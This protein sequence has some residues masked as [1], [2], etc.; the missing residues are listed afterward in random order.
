MTRIDYTSAPIYIY[1]YKNSYS[2]QSAKFFPAVSHSFSTSAPCER[3][4]NR[5]ENWSSERGEVALS[6]SSGRASLHS[7]LDRGIKPAPVDRTGDWNREVS[8]LP[9]AKWPV[10]GRANA[11]T[12]AYYLY[13]VKCGAWAPC[14]TLFPSLRTSLGSNSLNKYSVQGTSK[15]RWPWTQTEA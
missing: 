12:Q 4:I 2:G 15:S 8:K 14:V 7:H 5:W 3:S 6:R 9:K 10:S 11:K 13:D 1:I